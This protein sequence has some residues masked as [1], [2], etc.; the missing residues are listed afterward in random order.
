[1]NTV[2]CAM[3]GDTTGYL[4]AGGTAGLFS[5]QNFPVPAKAGMLFRDVFTQKA[6]RH[7]MLF[8]LYRKVRHNIKNS[9]C[10]KF[11]SNLPELERPQNGGMDD[12]I[13]NRKN[14]KRNRIDI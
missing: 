9:S 8:L 4:N 1:V 6:S 3:S 5:I 11:D 14:R 2:I 10:S 12:G 13:Y 7:W